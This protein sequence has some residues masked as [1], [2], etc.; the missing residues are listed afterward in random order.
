MRTIVK[1]WEIR[2]TRKAEFVY[3]APEAQKV[4]VLGD[5]NRWDQDSGHMI[6]GRD[7]KWRLTLELQ[8]GRYEYRFLVDGYWENDQAPV[9]CIPNAFGTWNCVLKVS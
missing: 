1:P 6:K 3:F 8:P 7:Q 2:S 9:E 5:F 4:Q